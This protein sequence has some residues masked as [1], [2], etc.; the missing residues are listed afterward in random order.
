MLFWCL[1]SSRNQDLNQIVST[2]FV[3]VIAFEFLKVKKYVDRKAVVLVVT[4]GQCP[5]STPDFPFRIFLLPGYQLVTIHKHKFV[6]GK[7]I[8]AHIL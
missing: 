4:T 2:T 5:M 1:S 6:Q 7:A 8:R 3:N